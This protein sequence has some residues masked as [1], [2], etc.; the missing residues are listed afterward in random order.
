MTRVLAVVVLASFLSACT[1]SPAVCGRMEKLCGTKR[2]DCEAL[3]K[4]TRE[5]LGEESVT[6]ITACFNDADSC[7]AASGCVVGKGMKTAADSAKTFLDAVDKEL[8]KK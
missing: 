2:E 3:V 6:A 7:E 8:R 5:N 4:N 1:S